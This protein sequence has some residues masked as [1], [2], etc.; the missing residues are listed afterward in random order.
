MA[1]L[2]GNALGSAMIMPILG[3]IVEGVGWIWAFVI[4]A[5]VTILWAGSWEFTVADSPAQHKWCTEE[6]QNYISESLSGK[7]KQVKVRCPKEICFRNCIGRLF[8]E[9]AAVL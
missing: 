7:V 9:N 2:M 8:L 4:P 6:E 1:A 5:I 3:L